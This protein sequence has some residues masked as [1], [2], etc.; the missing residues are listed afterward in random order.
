M[1]LIWR[2]V[3]DGGGGSM[4]P[5]VSALALLLVMGEEA[6]SST[7]VM[8]PLASALGGNLASEGWLSAFGLALSTFR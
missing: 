1:C 4:L 7:R 5:H 2:A 3:G 6:F 8:I